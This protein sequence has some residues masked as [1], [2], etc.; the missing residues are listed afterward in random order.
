M[1]LILAS[2]NA[3][4]A[5]EFREI[6]SPLGID[7]VTQSE[8]GCNFEAE[9]NGKTFRENARIKALAAMEATGLPSVADDSGIEVNAMNGGPGRQRENPEDFREIAR[10]LLCAYLSVRSPH[11]GSCGHF[12]SHNPAF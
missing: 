7:V 4:K 10:T 5:Q 12:V 9:E 8:A 6:L 2:N 3:H 11:N 1:K